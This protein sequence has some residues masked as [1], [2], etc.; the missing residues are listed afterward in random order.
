MREIGRCPAIQLNFLNMVPEPQFEYQEMPTMTLRQLVQ[1]DIIL[2][3]AERLRQIYVPHYRDEEA[4]QIIKARNLLAENKL[5]GKAYE[6]VAVVRGNILTL[7][8][9]AT[10]ILDAA[11]TSYQLMDAR[12]GYAFNT[13][14]FETDL[15]CQTWENYSRIC[16]YAIEPSTAM[17]YGNEEK[18]DTFLISRTIAERRINQLYFSPSNPYRT[19]GIDNLTAQLL[20]TYWSRLKIRAEMMANFGI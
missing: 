20:T 15:R 9:Y 10:I 2:A 16:G 7:E 8:I 11:D 3:A 18:L 4:G 17:K 5:P 19:E 6:N 14:D 12:A 1:E 13:P